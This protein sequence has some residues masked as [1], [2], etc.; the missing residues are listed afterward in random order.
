MPT[1]SRAFSEAL[2]WLL[3]SIAMTVAILFGEVPSWTLLLFVASVAWRYVIEW[4]RLAMPG[5]S[6]RL[7]IFV[8]VMLGMFYAFGAH[9]SAT[10]MLAFLVALLSLKVLELRTPRDFTVVAL[11]G[12]FMALSGFFY[13]QSLLVSL[14]LGVALWA[15]TVALVR[16]HG[17]GGRG[18]LA[19]TLRLSLLVILQALPLTALMFI[20][21]PRIQGTFLQRLSGDTRGQTGMSS[22]LQPG[23]FSSL[24]QSSD[25]AFRARILPK[26][27]TLMSP[28]LYWRGLVMDTCERGLSWR[29]SEGTNA[30]IK[31]LPEPAEARR[32]QQQ[33]I[34]VP[35][36]EH[37][38]FTLDHPVEYR[39][40][41]GT[42]AALT[43]TYV[44]RSS[45]PLVAN[46]TIY[47][48][49]SEIAPSIGEDLTPYDRARYTRLPADL[50]DDPHAEALA[51]GWRTR[52]RGGEPG[53]SED[54]VRAGLLFF[55]DGRF[56]YTLSPG[57]LPAK[58]AL[59][60]FLVRTRA[61]FCEH[62]AAAFC[63]LMRAAGLPA[64]IVIGYQGGEYN[65]FGGHY[66]VRQSDAHAW[67]EVWL[68]GAWTR[69]D[70]TAMV[71]PDR[72]SFGAN[73]YST[74]MADG[75]LSEESRLDRLR[76]IKAPSTL[77]WL[78]HQTLLAWDGVDQQWNLLVLGY[79]QEQQW[80]FLQKL[81]VGNL[82]WFGGTLL[83]LAA[84]FSLL[85]GGTLLFRWWER[86]GARVARDQNRRLY[87]RFCRRL[88]DAGVPPRAETEGP[89]DY[90]ARAATTLPAAAREIH[91][92]TDLY[93]A[94]RY[95]RPEPVPDK[96]GRAGRLRAAVSAFRPA[97]A[98]SRAR[99]SLDAGTKA[100][101]FSS[102]P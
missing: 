75:P 36:G 95:S 49:V 34:L 1:A 59:D 38:L 7:L 27:L 72:V 5:F 60:T 93:V 15:N 85:G 22:H 45:K 26:G 83:A 86:Q 64:R 88:A 3:G 82:S 33:I 31:K 70:P 81:G 74:L 92:I 99:K 47:T 57:E 65:S 71:A 89:L 67:V 35:H 91:R 2:P 46:N 62:Y 100:P 14:Y 42:S 48:A 6:I 25:V 58:A 52:A 37:W 43:N 54:I 73:D 53:H 102:S 28:Q 78:A 80:A 97:G 20:I 50:A 101:N 40:A 29:A 8:P 98:K 56:T 11:L 90:A 19:A 79:D 68:K 12:Y 23:S 61:G 66:V 63:T 96:A 13:N 77:R 39:A 94:L 84:A 9:P 30:E 41:P 87:L 24:A 10:A 16:A 21:F 76:R 69:E 55:R 4:R 32:V 51:E 44:L 18:K 17:G